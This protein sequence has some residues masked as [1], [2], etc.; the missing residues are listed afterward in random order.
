MGVG[1]EGVLEAIVLL[2]YRKQ[3][4]VPVLGCRDGERPPGG[5]EQMKKGRMMPTELLFSLLLNMSSISSKMLTYSP[6]LLSHHLV[7]SCRTN[8]SASTC[9][10]CSR[11]PSRHLTESEGAGGAATEEEGTAGRMVEV[12]METGI[13]LLPDIIRCCA[14]LSRAH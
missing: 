14:V 10:C 13:L 8:L 6:S 5:S 2:H 4:T 11:R 9:C 12:V 1:W 7:A 3:L